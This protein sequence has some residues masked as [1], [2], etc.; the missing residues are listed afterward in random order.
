VKLCRDIRI[1]PVDLLDMVAQN[2]NRFEAAEREAEARK[3]T[4]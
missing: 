2:V 1:A 4:R 3:E